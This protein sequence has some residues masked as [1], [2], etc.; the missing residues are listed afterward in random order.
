[1]AVS[2]EAHSYDLNRQQVVTLDEIISDLA[3]VQTV[4]VGES[5]DQW[6]HHQAQLQIIQELFAA[7]AEVHIGLEMFRRD[8]QAELDRWVAGELDEAEFS[9]I[10]SRHWGYWQLYR[11]IFI[12]ARDN[13]IRLLGLNIKRDIVNQVARSGF[14]SLSAQQRAKLPL[15]ACNVNPAYR[16]YIRR[17]LNGHPLDATEFEHFCEAQILWDASMARSLA[18][19]LQQSP[20]ATVVVLAGSGHSWRY[21]IPEQLAR[22]GAFSSRVLLPEIPG[23]IDLQRISEADADYLLQGVEQA[24]LH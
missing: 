3:Q 11:D 20:H 1:V 9:Q 21:G 6:A 12:Y 15:A 14:S 17:S 16:S 7:G 18:D 5:H 19:N 22:L 8:G 2:A 24:P 4:F 10:F 23:Q 13:G